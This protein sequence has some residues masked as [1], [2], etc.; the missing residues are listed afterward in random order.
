[1]QKASQVHTRPFEVVS[2]PGLINHEQAVAEQKAF[3]TR[4][5][6][7]AA[8]TATKQS[9]VRSFRATEFGFEGT[10]PA[11]ISPAGAFGDMFSG[12]ACSAAADCLRT[13]TWYTLAVASIPIATEHERAPIRYRF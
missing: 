12:G 9:V 13:I 5:S 1:M 8:I 7:D 2:A 11:N 10:L 3:L 6:S 4:Q